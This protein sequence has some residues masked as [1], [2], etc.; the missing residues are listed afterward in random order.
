MA[1][2]LVSLTRLQSAD[3]LMFWA[4]QLI[5]DLQRIFLGSGAGFI[6]GDAIL[7]GTL[8]TDKLL[9]TAGGLWSG[10]QQDFAPGGPYTIALPNI[11]YS[12]GGVVLTS[13]MIFA[14][15]FNSWAHLTFYCHFVTP[16][17]VSTTV[18]LEESDNSGSTWFTRAA[19]TGGL[20]VDCNIAMLMYV[21]ANAR[22][23]MR[24]VNNDTATK[25]IGG[26]AALF[27]MGIIGQAVE[28]P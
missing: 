10:T 21:P 1:K 9:A 28:P 7:D 8:G 23:R 15:A 4:R 20:P 19:W 14:P 13:N 6:D 26:P 18:T 2:S 27:T 22:F 12:S 5:D 24:L 11:W 17:A 3:D 16:N 25:S